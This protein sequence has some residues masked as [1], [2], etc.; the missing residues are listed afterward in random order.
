[1]ASVNGVTRS[2]RRSLEDR[3]ERSYRQKVKIIR[4]WQHGH[5]AQN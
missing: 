3:L 2:K 1:M 5:A 4:G